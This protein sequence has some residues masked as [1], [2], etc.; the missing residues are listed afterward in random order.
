MD[1]R[2]FLRGLIA[3]TA[4]VPIASLLPASEIVDLISDVE[5][6]IDLRPGAVNWAVNIGYEVGD[7][8]AGRG[9]RYQVISSDNPL[10]FRLPTGATIREISIG[11]VLD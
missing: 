3:S 6:D 9:E 10:T 11:P 1:R 7:I 8:V 5:F 2:S 4:A